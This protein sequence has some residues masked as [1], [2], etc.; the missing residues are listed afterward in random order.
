MKGCNI[1][2]GK[3]EEKSPLRRSGYRWENNMKIALKE[4]GFE[5]IE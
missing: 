2:V 5:D 1:S 4:I 3:P